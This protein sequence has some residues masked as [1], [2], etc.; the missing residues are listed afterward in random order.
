M[1]I[2]PAI[3][4]KDSEEFWLRAEEIEKLPRITRVQVDFCDGKF[5]PDKSVSVQELDILNPMLSWEAH[6]M[7]VEPVDFLDYKLLGFS[8]IVVHAEAFSGTSEGEKHLAVTKALQEIKQL[9]MKTGLAIN[10][11]TPVHNVW[12]FKDLVDQFTL[13]TVHPGKQGGQFVPESFERVREFR[14]LLPEG[15]LEIDGG[16]NEANIQEFTELGVDAC[17]VGS[18]LLFDTEKNLYH[19]LN[20]SHEQE[21]GGE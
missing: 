11:E 16:V 1:Q 10:P 12:A 18:A 3:L 20:L 6:L 15:F 17:A 4:A 13:M 14:E 8:L 21:F 7:V 9:G 19:L 5:V 2:I